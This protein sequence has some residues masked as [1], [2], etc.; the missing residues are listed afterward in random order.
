MVKNGVSAQ[1]RSQL[2]EHT[3]PPVATDEACHRE[4]GPEART[5]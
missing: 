1:R 5:L 4:V 3:Q 2:R